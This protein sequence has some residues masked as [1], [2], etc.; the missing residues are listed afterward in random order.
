VAADRAQDQTQADSGIVS[1][2]APL[3]KAIA[4]D[5]AELAL[6]GFALH[7]L[8]CGA[9][10]ISRWDQSAYAPDLRAVRGFLDRVKGRPR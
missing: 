6:A 4:T 7:R 1:D 9:F 10:L 3:D 2:A 8:T 5:A